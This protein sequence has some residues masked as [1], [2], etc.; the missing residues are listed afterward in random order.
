MKDKIIFG[1]LLVGQ[2]VFAQGET[3]PFYD[4]EQLYDIFAHPYCALLI[5]HIRDKRGHVY[6]KAAAA[7]ELS[8]SETEIYIERRVQNRLL[9]AAL[10]ANVAEYRH[11]NASTTTAR[12]IFQL[13]ERNVREDF[14]SGA[15]IR[16]IPYDINP[17]PLTILFY[18][19][20]GRRRDPVSRLRYRDTMP[21]SYSILE[22]R[23]PIGEYETA[24]FQTLIFMKLLLALYRSTISEEILKLPV[25]ETKNLDPTLLTAVN[26]TAVVAAQA[27]LVKILST[28][29][30][31]DIEDL[32]IRF[33]ASGTDFETVLQSTMSDEKIPLPVRQEIKT[34]ES[35]DR[36]YRQPRCGLFKR[37]VLFIRHYY[38]DPEL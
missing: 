17:T 16:Q 4:D 3:N 22:Q 7:R 9:N 20:Y 2:A 19:D 5:E 14:R 23:P 21:F 34:Q 29:Q 10:N 8:M 28:E 11:A 36:F 6:R 35:F 32:F 24:T 30:F 37:F 26:H 31:E 15:R 18:Q 13:R 1:L 38:D 33:E 12:F 25:V 27:H